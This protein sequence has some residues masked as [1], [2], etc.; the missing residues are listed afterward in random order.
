VHESP[1]VEQ[2]CPKEG[3]PE[4][5]KQAVVWS[6]LHVPGSVG[7]VVVQAAAVTLQAPGTIGHSASL[8][9]TSEGT[10]EHWPA[11]GQSELERHAAASALHVPAT[12][13]H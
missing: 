11:A 5:S 7:Q 13:G 1:V 3:Q 8:W 12:V 4:S 9:H 2:V 6:R 10:I